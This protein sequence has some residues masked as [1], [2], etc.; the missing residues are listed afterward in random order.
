MKLEI[1]RCSRFLMFL[2]NFKTRVG[3][4]SGVINR[5]FW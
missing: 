4:V 1:R 2:V 5:A 3:G